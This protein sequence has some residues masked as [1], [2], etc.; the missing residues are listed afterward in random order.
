MR[1][2]EPSGG[3][4]RA[5]RRASLS[6]PMLAFLALSALATASPIGAQQSYPSRP[7]KI[8]APQGP[9]GGVDL[10]AR[11]LGE[12]LQRALGQPFVVDNQA[13]AGGAIATRMVAHASPDGTA[14]IA[15]RSAEHFRKRHERH[16]RTP[17]AAA[18][19]ARAPGP[20]PRCIP[21]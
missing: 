18:V 8:V 10:V 5:P 12:R 13:G 17:R 20:D 15:D 4:K 1:R 2:A 19:R 9:G 21:G 3:W 14:G 7:V 11:M 6:G 16:V